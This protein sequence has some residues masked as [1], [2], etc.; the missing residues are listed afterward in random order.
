MN[1]HFTMS[2]EELDLWW[3]LCLRYAMNYTYD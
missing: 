3:M 1:L 2:L